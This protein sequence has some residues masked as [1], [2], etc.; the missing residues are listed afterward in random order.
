MFKL[1]EICSEDISIIN[2]WRN[3]KELVDKL[4]ATYRYVNEDIDDLW[5]QNYLKNR[6]NNIRCAILNE[7]D[8]IIGVIYLLD[9]DYLNRNGVLH[10]M[11]GNQ[12]SRN[13][14]AGTFAVKEILNHAF[15]NYN[16]N[17]VELEVLSTNEFAQNFYKKLGF[18]SEGIKRKCIYKNGNYID[19]II[20]SILK[21]EWIN[22]DI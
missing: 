19:M 11:I 16:L 2:S 20:M 12:V 3:N 14:G 15:N 21:D 7:E 8:N 5:Y 13:N 1:R 4:G 17:R 9:I 10:I 22:E 6:N 18:V